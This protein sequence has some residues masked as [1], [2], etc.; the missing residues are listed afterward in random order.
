MH[1]FLV[2]YFLEHLHGL[3]KLRV[4]LSRFVLCGHRE[5]N[6]PDQF[7]IRELPVICYPEKGDP[8]AGIFIL[9]SYL[10]SGRPTASSQ[11]ARR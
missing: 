3:G 8:N 4:Q 11:A 1:K 9:L 10:I 2:R 7:L 6:G 5:T